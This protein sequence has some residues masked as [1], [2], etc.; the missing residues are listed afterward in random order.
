MIL[1]W[2]YVPYASSLTVDW[3]SEWLLHKSYHAV[4]EPIKASEI[5]RKV[6][7]NQYNKDVR[8]PL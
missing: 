4:R 7:K 5:V 1:L 8:T 3:K 2:F 6:S